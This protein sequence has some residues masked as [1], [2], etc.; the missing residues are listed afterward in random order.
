MGSR[1][2]CASGNGSGPRA[3]RQVGVAAHW[4]R[5]AYGTPGLGWRTR[6]RAIAWDGHRA[7][8]SIATLARRR[9][10]VRSVRSRLLAWCAKG[11]SG[12]GLEVCCHDT[13][14]ARSLGWETRYCVR[15]TPAPVS[16]EAIHSCVLAATLAVLH[17]A[18]GGDTRGRSTEAGAKPGPV[19][20]KPFVHSI[21][22]VNDSLSHGVV[23]D[24]FLS[25]NEAI[26]LHNRTLLPSQLSIAEQ[27]QLSGAGS[28]IAWI[29]IDASS[30][31]T[32]TVER[33]FDVIQDW[34]HGFLLQGYNG[35][36]EI[37]FTGP[38]IQHGFRATSNFASW[39]N[40]I[41]RGGPRG[42]ELSQTDA[43]FGG[44]VLDHVTFTGQSVAGFVG[45][46]TSTGGYGRVLFTRCTFSNLP[47]AAVLD[48]SANGRTSVFVAFDT[49]M[50]G[51]TNGI[52]VL[53]GGGGAAVV[54]VE[55]VSIE[56]TAAA[57]SLRRTAGGDRTTNAS[58]LHMR[59]RGGSGVSVA[60]SA[61]GVT[62]VDV[63]GLDV[64]AQSSALSLGA[65]GAGVSGLVEDSRL[66]GGVG[67]HADAGVGLTGNNL[68]ANGGA[69]ALS[70]AGGP[71]R[72]RRTRFLGSSIG[73][74][75]GVG[76]LLEDCSIEGGSAQGSPAAALTL[77]RCF[78]SAGALGANA[79]VSS[80]AGVAGIGQLAVNPF[81]ANSGGAVQLASE[82]PTG[83]VGLFVLGF[84]AATPLLVD[85]D[86]HVYLDLAVSVTLPGVTFGQQTL[87]LPIPA[88]PAFWDTEWIAQSA[89]L[90]PAG[91]PTPA[92]HALP[93]Q[94]FVIRL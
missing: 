45:A 32:I 1:A 59:T 69:V 89:V 39:R 25:V 81:V 27:I 28:D 21:A 6:K 40:L 18:V 57:F 56:A 76:A 78:A 3:D 91:S 61:I 85:A 2:R 71:L 41:L 20:A 77:V 11:W 42:I 60:G 82:M 88:D 74:V 67:L 70:S 43:S 16:N 34:P 7:P 55:R 9:A 58:F 86:L 23:G 12:V 93:P 66:A 50:V 5:G 63:R 72:V 10:H 54:Q 47:T 26:Q 64:V 90:A 68:H 46:G 15:P 52:D 83:H 84:P 36:A 49:Q 33:D 31:P 8:G 13:P 17:G 62:A 29:N 87:T 24:S 37:D 44:T 65:L 80:P 94:R 51:V 48:E 19:A 73:A 53:L 75:G 22:E 35:D 4:R 14:G 79:V 92:V 30:V 38:G